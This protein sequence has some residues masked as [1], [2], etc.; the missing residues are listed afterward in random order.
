MLNF[1]RDLGRRIKFQLTSAPMAVIFARGS[2]LGEAK[3]SK[4]EAD[5]FCM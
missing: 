4:E 5:T 3:A 1:A 2:Q